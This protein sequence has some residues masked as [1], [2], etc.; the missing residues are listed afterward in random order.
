[1]GIYVSYDDAIRVILPRDL[2]IGDEAFENVNIGDRVN[3]QIQK[4]RFQVNDT[5]ILSVGLFRGVVAAGA[6]VAPPKEEAAPPAVTIVEEAAPAA[7]EEEEAA[8]AAVEEEEEAT[9][10]ATAAAAAN[11]NLLVLNNTNSTGQDGGGNIEFYSSKPEFKEFSNFYSAPFTL[12]GK[13]WPTVEHYFQAAKFPGNPTYQEQIRQAK[14]AAQAKKLGASKEQKIREDWDAYRISV[15]EKAVRAKFEQ[16]ES[17]RKMLLST[18]NKELAEAS[19]TD[20]FWGI[21]K[22]KNGEN[23]LGKILMNLRKDLASAESKK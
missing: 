21:G 7:V 12:D 4:S 11:E 6:S 15:M 1:M 19:P 23:R 17:L 22:K 2:H 10:P 13:A 9:A 20:Y 5:Y 18:G 3:V 16:N 8:P 14:T